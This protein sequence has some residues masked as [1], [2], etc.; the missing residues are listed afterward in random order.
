M[1]VSSTTSRITYTAGGGTIFAYIFRIFNKTDLVV[2]NAGVLQVVDVDYTVTG[3]GLAG[4]GNVV[5]AI[6]PTVGNTIIIYRELPLTQLIDYQEGDPFPAETHEAGLDRL[7]MISQQFA[8]SVERFLK[9]PDTST[10][11]GIEIPVGA[12]KGIRW[13]AAGNN[14]ELFSIDAQSTSVITTEGDM[15]YG[16]A[17]GIPERLPIG[18]VG[19]A[20]TRQGNIPTWQSPKLDDL[21]IPDD[22]TDLDVSITKHGL[23]PKAPNSITK[24]LRGDDGNW[25]D[26]PAAT[27]MSGDTVQVVNVETG[28]VAT[29]TTATPYDDTIPQS[30]EGDEYITLAITPTSATNKLK[31]D[32]VVNCSYS[33]ANE[34]ITVALFQDAIVNALAAFC[35]SSAASATL[36]ISIKF[37]HHMVAGTTS[38]ITLKIRIGGVSGGATL[39]FN[40]TAGAR[41]MGGVMA[42]SITI[43]E[44]QV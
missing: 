8:S 15:I 36:P 3:I 25:H 32:V 30:N 40:G 41:K 18:A 31:I 5:F 17:G 7:V 38:E 13:N 6:A 23:T 37:T 11:V 20:L 28:A 21:A 26:L 14:F 16:V 42:S 33:N 12:N 10:L 44:I 43:T 34:T 4:G 24:F 2:Y 22:N 27:K 39:T 1:T 29:G 19:V 35:A 9:L